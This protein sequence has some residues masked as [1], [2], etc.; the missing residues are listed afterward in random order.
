MISDL[1][2]KRYA[3]EKTEPFISAQEKFEEYGKLS[4][5]NLDEICSRRTFSFGDGRR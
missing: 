1:I 4:H 2:D 5:K 3:Y